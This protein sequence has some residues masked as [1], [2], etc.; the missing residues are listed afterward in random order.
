MV[1]VSSI[2]DIRGCGLPARLSPVLQPATGRGFCRTGGR[3]RG[4]VEED[5]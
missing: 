4:E 2:I 3:G 1:V 5:R